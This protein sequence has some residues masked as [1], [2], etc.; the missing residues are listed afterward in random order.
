MRYIISTN[1]LKKMMK[2]QKLSQNTRDIIFTISL[3]KKGHCYTKSETDK[4]ID[5][6]KTIIDRGMRVMKNDIINQV[7]QNLPTNDPMDPSLIVQAVMEKMK[8]LIIEKMEEQESQIFS[9]IMR[10]RNEQVKDRVGRKALTIPK[11]P[12]TWIP[13]LKASEI[14]GVTTLQEII[15]MNVYIRRNDRYHHAKSDLVA[16]QFDQLEFFFRKDFKTYECYFNSCPSDWNME[17]FVE[18]IIIPKEI[19][20]EEV[21][22]IE[23][24]N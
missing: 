9:A 1:T 24:E 5:D 23:S 14:N 8:P 21:F 16:S 3:K 19:K 2:Y 10:F 11:T 6:T 22:E 13:L 12:Y 4:I 7:N 18:Y 20:S 15:I 17:C